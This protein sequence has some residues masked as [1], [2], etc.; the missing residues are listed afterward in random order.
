MCID[1]NG[2]P[3][4][5]KIR[6][7]SSYGKKTFTQVITEEIDLLTNT[8]EKQIWLKDLNDLYKKIN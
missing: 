1:T 8:T 5:L 4:Q 3:E 7:F 2:T 6:G